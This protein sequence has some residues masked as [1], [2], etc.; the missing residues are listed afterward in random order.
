MS[1]SLARSLW[2]WAMRLATPALLARWWWRGWAE[3]GYR[4]AMRERLGVYAGKAEAGR[5]WLHAVSL[6]ETL[7][8]APLVDALRTQQPGLRLLLTHTT[9]TGRAAGAKLLREGDAQCWLPLDTPGACRRFFAHWRP[10][11]GVLMETE[12]WPV[13][14]AESQRAGVPVT[15]ANARLSERSLK[16]GERFGGLLRAAAARLRRVIAQTETDAERLRRMGAA[17]VTVGGNLKFD[18]TPDAALLAR[19]RAWRAAAGRPVILFAVSREGEEAMLLEAWRAL[20]PQALLLVVPRH[21]QRFDEVAGLLEGAG[22]RL[23]RRSG[24]GE[25]APPA[26]AEAW[27]GD[28]LGE[29]PAYYAA[30]DVALLG[31]SFAPLGGQNLIQAA[32]CACPLL[33]GPSTFNFAD[34]AEGALE[35]GAAERVGDLQTALRRAM[36][37]LDDGPAREAM[38]AAGLRFAQAHQ[39]AAVRIAASLLQDLRPAA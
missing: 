30:A 24:W 14:L 22:L 32:S 31:G 26:D 29:M 6:G 8:A 20:R 37:L 16:K 18:S 5:L 17:P 36:Q 39:G 9:A 1:D 33:L 10:R 3:P 13:L 28:S 2:A 38:A 35:A 7:A 34:A 23:A 21:P 4:A 19:G 11:A 25:R 27:L 15:L 12:V